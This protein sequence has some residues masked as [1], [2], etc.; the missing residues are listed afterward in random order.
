M[1]LA[2]ATT[3]LAPLKAASSASR[4]RDFG[5]VDELAMR[6]HPPNRVVDTF[7]ETAALCDDVDERNRAW[8]RCG[9]GVIQSSN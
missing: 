2:Q 7:A 5:A 6:Q 3:C 8:G 1:P 9:S 4:L